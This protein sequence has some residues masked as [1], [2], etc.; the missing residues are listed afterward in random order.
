MSPITLHA[1][2]LTH[3]PYS[4]AFAQDFWKVRRNLT[5][6][7]G[8]RLERWGA[9]ELKNGNGSTF[10]PKIGKVIAA[11]VR[12]N[13]CSTPVSLS[14]NYFGAIMACGLTANGTLQ[15]SGEPF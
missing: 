3:S 2:G 1:F 5:L 4:G 11:P 14:G 13:G 9:K 8:L 7:L 12:L 10:D 6:S 15:R